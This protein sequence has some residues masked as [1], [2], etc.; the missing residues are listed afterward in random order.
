MERLPAME[1]LRRAA[2]GAGMLLRLSEDAQ[3]RLQE[4]TLRTDCRRLPAAVV[5]DAILDPLELIW[6]VAEKT[7]VVS[8]ASMASVE[9]IGRYRQQTAERTLRFACE[10]APDHPWAAAS[11]IELGRVHAASGALEVAARDVAQ[12]LESYPRS[13]FNLE[14]WF[15]LAKLQ[16]RLGKMNA[17]L[18]SC[19]RAADVAGGQPL[20]SAC[21][22][23]VGRVQLE[24]DHPRDSVP[25]LTRA[26]ALAKGTPLEPTA[27][28]MLSAAYFL[29]ENYP[30]ANQVLLDHGASFRANASLDRAAFLSALIRYRGARDDTDRVREGAT[31][32]GALTNAQSAGGFGGHWNYLIALGFRDAAM[33]TEEAAALRRGLEC[34]RLFP[35]QHRMRALLL[36]DSAPLISSQTAK[37]VTELRSRPQTLL[38]QAL[39]ADASQAARRGG[40]DETLRLCRQ[41]LEQPD[42]PE[43]CRRE[44]LQLMG[45]TYQMLGDHERAIKCFTGLVPDPP[46]AAAPRAADPAPGGPL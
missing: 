16:L 36:D 9:E 28:L 7:V 34:G 33:P 41:I 30:R 21:Y 18:A 12:A 32:I 4:R 46:P 5:C 13:E 29:L 11:Q 14:A 1:V 43:P 17:A 45:R 27:A 31:L 37:E 10:I 35:L 15:N 22:L 23:Y 40:A 26:D 42:V 6:Q 24:M 2:A 19:I 3:T 20:E 38:A 25:A 8:S 44:A 39:L